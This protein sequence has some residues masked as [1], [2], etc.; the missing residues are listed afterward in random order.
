MPNHNSVHAGSFLIRGKHFNLAELYWFWK[1]FP[2]VLTWKKNLSKFQG[3]S[4]GLFCS[5]SMFCNT[6]TIS[7]FGNKNFAAQM[8]LHFSLPFCVL[9]SWIFFRKD[10]HSSGKRLS[11]PISR[12]K[13]RHCQE[14]KFWVLNFAYS[15]SWVH[16]DTDLMQTKSVE[17]AS[18]WCFART[19]FVCSWLIWSLTLGHRKRKALPL[20]GQGDGDWQTLRREVA[21][22]AYCGLKAG[23]P[24]KHT[25]WK[26][27]DVFI[28]Y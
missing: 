25:P 17:G 22:R 10:F 18:A 7:S 27:S 2:E 23:F 11:D 24:N 1:H 12:L 26:K 21:E 5:C 15:L 6:S 28:L 19:Y 16:V 3:S 9:F 14:R 20:P 4:P 8:E 13:P